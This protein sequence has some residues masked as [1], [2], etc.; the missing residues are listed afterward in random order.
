MK[1]KRKEHGKRTATINPT[2]KN[3]FP[4]DSLKELA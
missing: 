4:G 1:K 2:P 3:S